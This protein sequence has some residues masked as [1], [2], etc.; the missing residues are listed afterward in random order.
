MG[1]IVA[2]SKHQKGNE[3]RRKG[4]QLTLC[5]C[6]IVVISAPHLSAFNLSASVCEHYGHLY[7]Y[8]PPELRFEHSSMELIGG[9]SN[10][11]IFNDIQ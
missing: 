9:V 8:L 6:K 11:V 2:G 1:L 5:E 3:L 4:L 10:S 7:T